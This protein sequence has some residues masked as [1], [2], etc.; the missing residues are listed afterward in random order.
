LS[1]AGQTKPNTK[2]TKRSQFLSY[3]KENKRDFGFPTN[4]DRLTPRFRTLR[5]LLNLSAVTGRR[6]DA[7]EV[8]EVHDC[9]ASRS[10]YSPNLC[11]SIRFHCDRRASIPEAGDRENEP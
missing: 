11:Q 6:S 2:N 9:T 8:Q 10:T 5:T 7:A 4:P 1:L 3:P